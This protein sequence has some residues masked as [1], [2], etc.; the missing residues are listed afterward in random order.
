EID[1][2]RENIFLILGG[3][4]IKDNEMSDALSVFRQLVLHFPASY[5][6]R[7]FLGKIHS[8]KGNYK[9]AESQLKKAISL[10]PEL[11]EPRF[12]LLNVYRAQEKKQN[13][14]KIY[15]IYKDILER[16]PDNIRAA[17]E[18]GLY[19]HE[20]GKFR[21][22]QKLFISLG[23]RSKSKFTVILNILQ[24]YIDKKKYKDAINILN[25]ML[26]GAPESSTIHHI[27]G[28]ASYGIK[29]THRAMKHFKQV[30]PGSR[31][32]QDA[33][34]H[35]SYIYQDKGDVNKAINHLKETLNKTP[36]DP[37]LLYYLSMFHEDTKKYKEAETTLKKAIEI[38]PDEE[39]FLFRL[40]V[41][42]DKWNRKEDSIKTM[43]AV[44][45][46]NPKHAN[47]LNYLGYTYADLGI[48]LDEAERLIKE[49]LKHKPGDGYITDSLGWV[50]FKKGLYVEALNLLKKAV[51][52]VP[53]DPIMLEHLGDAYHKTNDRVNALKF[54]KRALQNKKENKAPLE[55]KIKELTEVK[56]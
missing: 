40:G 24:L 29:N 17:L 11:V 12:E 50:F 14:E 30:K 16:N 21:D 46:L 34:L 39:K 47:A 2:S 43:K 27:A 3:L 32:F 26:K 4:H 23:K 31:F 53:D 41:V 38:S 33:M 10:Q 44:I 37:E 55:R 51:E 13:P 6:G 15:Q 28:L 5:P 8:Q 42:Y 7:F 1:K 36:D 48:N 22:A 18:L 54:Y 9:E 19:Y 45:K 25:G 56:P 20:K 49:A 52:L 35:I